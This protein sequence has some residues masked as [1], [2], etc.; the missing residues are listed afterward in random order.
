MADKDGAKDATQTESE[1]FLARAY[2]LKTAGQARSLYRDWAPSYDQH[3][4][5]ELRY[6][7]PASIAAL[8]ADSIEDREARVLDIG[9]GTGLVAQNLVRHG[10][11]TIDGLDFS[12]E[13]LA[14]AQAKSIYRGLIQADLNAALD[15]P[16]GFYDAAISCGTFTHGHVSAGALEEILR[17]IK[18]GGALA[19][20]VHREIWQSSGFE[21]KLDFLEKERVIAVEK[22]SDQPYFE[23]AEPEGR[24]CLV[25]RL[26]AAE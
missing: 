24:Y 3:L 20:T 15:L 1:R 23:G 10:F 5:Q 16:S 13:M 19:C 26:K 9:C 12:P 6:I 4:E 14:V 21:Q 11:R 17:L 2:S 7:G 25:R 22:M 8:L 18:P